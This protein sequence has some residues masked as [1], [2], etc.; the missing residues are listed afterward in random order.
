M[1][2]PIYA[3]ADLAAIYDALDP[4]RSDLL[5]Y[6]GIVAEL[7][8]RSVL[9][10]GCGTGTFATLL[11]QCGVSVVGVDP[12]VASVELART[13]PYADQVTWVAGDLAA[14]PPLQVDLVTMTANVAQVFLA[15]EDWR[16]VLVGAHSALR[17]GGHLVFETRD[18][19]RAA[20]NAWNRADSHTVTF[21]GGVGR[22]ETW[23]DLLQVDDA[24]ALVTFRHTF[25]LPDG[26][27]RVSESTLRFR[28]R[29]EVQSSLDAAL[30]TIDIRDAPDRAGLEMVFVARA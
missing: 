1:A 19:A 5:A 18:P 14:V 11:A 26:A 12:A 4:D 22:V 29:E 7:R 28:S 2:D 17:S 21:I 23:L 16:A 25:V 30:E 27:R 13:K 3:D 8:A 20:W 9:D 24:H 10:I 15:D 6:A